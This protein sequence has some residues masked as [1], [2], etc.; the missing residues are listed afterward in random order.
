MG[1]K[2]K[3]PLMQCGSNNVAKENGCN[4]GEAV[5]IIE[6]GQHCFT[7]GSGTTAIVTVTDQCTLNTILAADDKC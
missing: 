5:K 4:C 7:A 1:Y 6:Y 3:T 2:G